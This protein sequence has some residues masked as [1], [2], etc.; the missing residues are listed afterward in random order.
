MPDFS[1]PSTRFHP[2]RS[3]EDAPIETLMAARVRAA[4]TWGQLQGR[5]AHLPPEVAHQF[6]AALARLLLVEALAGSGFSGANSWF[7]AW[8]AGLEPVPDATA[9]VAAPASLIADTLLAELSLSAWAP[10]ADTATQI[11]AA[12]HFHRGEGTHAQHHPQHHPQQD[13]REDAPAVAVA[14]AARL[15]EP[16]ADDRTDDPGDEPG[17]DWPLA[18][19][20]RLH[21]AAA[22]SP[23]F[24]PTERSYQ[25]L[26]LPAG[27]VSFEQTRTATPLWA[28][29]LLAGPLI[30]RSAPA[31]R[32]LPLPGAV[33]AEALRPEL[34]PRERAILTAEAA[35]KTAQRLSDQLDAAH[36]SVRDMQEAMTVLRS[37]SRAPL[38]YRLLAGF[39]PLRPLQIEKAL[40]VSKNGVR[41][42]VT[43]LVKAGLAE[44]AAH[45]HHTII[46][47]LP[48]AHR[49]APAAEGESRSV[50]TSTD[51][52]F[53]AFDAAMAD[54]ERVL[55]RMET[56]RE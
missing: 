36:A 39:G 56:A 10:L 11:R 34:W 4:L 32:P 2:L 28:L 9:H 46:R 22:A 19:L 41:D 5:L 54:V 35:G 45:G 24:A 31:T 51:A 1:D 40:G 42:L 38:L 23:H 17:D 25:L 53:A 37:T 18:A 44:R 43:A 55:A 48:R 13:Q 14:E 6:C 50:E 20:D 30:A 47:A 8:F 33:R 49:A 12:A 15:A 29:D 27:P 21:R 26:P 7:S 16:P 3:D 52:T